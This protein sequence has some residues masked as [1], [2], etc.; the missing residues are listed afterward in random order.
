MVKNKSDLKNKLKSEI[1]ARND[2][3]ADLI[4]LDGFAILWVVHWHE[5]GKVFDFIQSFK[6]YVSECLKQ[7]DVF[8]IFD[9][10]L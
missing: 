6:N 4:I 10:Y 9:K 5:K 1:P 8:L 7:S 3:K 2:F